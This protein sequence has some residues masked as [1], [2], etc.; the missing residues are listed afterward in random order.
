MYAINTELYEA[1]KGL[2]NLN[3]RS[4][5]DLVGEWIDELDFIPLSKAPTNMM[6]FSMKVW[7]KKVRPKLKEGAQQYDD[8]Y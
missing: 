7:L 3:I 5:P 8:W 4:N 2:K 6:C 1:G